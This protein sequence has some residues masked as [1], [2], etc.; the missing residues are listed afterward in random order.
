[1]EDEPM[2]AQAFRDQLRSPP[3][4]F[5]PIPF[6]SWNERLDVGETRRQAAEM[7]RVGIGGYFMHARGG[8]QTEYLG[9]EWLANIAA[10]VD[11]ARQRGLGAWAYDEN[12]WP[13]G[14]GNGKVN[15]KGLKYQQKYLRWEETASA[16]PRP[17]GRTITHL[18]LPDG[19]LLHFHF[20]VNPFYVDTLDAEVIADFLREIY[21]PYA[22]RFQGDF[23]AAMPGFF[24]DEPQVSRNGIPWSFVLPERYRRAYGEELLPLLPGL[25]L[26]VGTWRRTRYRFWHLVQELFVTA[27]TEPIYRWCSRHGCHLTGHMV[28]EETLHSQITSN[29]AVMPHY[30]FFHVPGLDWLGRQIEPPTT[31]L[32]VASVAQQLGKRQVLSETFAL[33]GWNVSFE[34][35]KWMF[36]WQMVRGAT[37]LCQHLE[38][39]SL[40]G[41]RKRDYPPSLFF[42]QPWWERYGQFNDA[43]S[44]VGMLLSL[45][46]PC[47]DVLVLHPQSSAWI[48]F[49]NSANRGLDERY[50]AFLGLTKALEAAHIPFHYGDERILRRYGSAG[51]GILRVGRCDY[52]AVIVPP[53]LTVAASTARLLRDFAA[54]GGLLIWC[55]TEPPTLIEGEEPAATDLALAGTGVVTAS[56]A[57]AIAALPAALRRIRVRTPQG[58]EAETVAVTERAFGASLAGAPFRLV[59]L[60]NSGRDGDLDTQIALPG[61]SVCRFRMESGETVP[62]ASTGK[63]GRLTVR[64]T[65][66]PAGSLV[67]F[68]ADTPAAWPRPRRARRPTTRRPLAA[69][70][71]GGPWD[72]E[73]LDPNALTLDTCDIAFDGETIARQ[74][75]ISVVQKRALDLERPVDIELRFGV[76]AAAG[77]APPAGCRLVLEQPGRTTITVNGRRLAGRDLGPYWDTSFRQIDLE[78][79]LTPGRNEIVLQTRFTQPAAVY[80]NLRR[81]RVFEAEKNKLTYDSEIEACYLV[82]P[83]GVEA[84]GPL[85]S[86]PR[87][88]WR[89]PG[90]FVLTP[91]PRQADPANLT[92]QGLPFFA[93]S[94][95]LSRRLVLSEADAAERSFVYRGL[96]GHVLRL[97][98][99]GRGLGEWLWRPYEADLAGALQAGENLLELE[100]T[101][102]LRNLLGPH[103]LREGESYGVGPWSFFKE[104]NI[105][106]CQPWDERYC[107]VSFGVEF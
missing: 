39:Y 60:V 7:A 107:V 12:G 94:V 87:D 48:D 22:E 43:M 72:L 38:G 49:D 17:D 83:F 44:R 100:L 41:I 35:L 9:P 40:R 55:G 69:T 15:G 82:G 45:G 71:L 18:R 36:E 20:D 65:F 70:D 61:R 76:T 6:W 14:F 25:F 102:G 11:E 91:V 23:G 68:V 34:E 59:Y 63:G 13:S 8:L 47:Q 78:N 26:E 19:R 32:Q 73:L 1:M 96:R 106:G 21:E 86:L 64:H 95:R 101:G 37:L 31:P 24:T 46:E 56:L 30:E 3:N 89:C 5:R 51:G 103:H 62:I 29:A 80:E 105:W 28:L 81:A 33:T 92:A 57:E 98:V 42:Q 16:T 54:S 93:G 97:R 10:G 53:V 52:R 75:H 84:A 104:P 99:N 74:E 90:P 67:L 27:F 88:A 50:A 79:S 4:R 2:L 85:E 58:A 77:F 66:P